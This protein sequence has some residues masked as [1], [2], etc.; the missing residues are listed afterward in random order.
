M[1]KDFGELTLRCNESEF[2]NGNGVA[3]ITECFW[4]F[5]VLGYI[6]VWVHPSYGSVEYTTGKKLIEIYKKEKPIFDRLCR[7]LHE[8]RHTYYDSPDEESKSIEKRYMRSIKTFVTE[9]LKRL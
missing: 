2:M 5:L 4:T 3:M 9:C 6:D 1:K 8:A 7:Q